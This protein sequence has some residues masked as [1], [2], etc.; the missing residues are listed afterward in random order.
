MKRH[1]G[2]IQGFESRFRIL[3]GT[4][5]KIVFAHFRSFGLYM[6]V[7]DWVHLF[8]FRFENEKWRPWFL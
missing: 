1:N 4:I 6:S 7:L 3:L 2:D 5:A 8:L